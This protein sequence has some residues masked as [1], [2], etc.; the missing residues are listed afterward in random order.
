[1]NEFSKLDAVLEPSTPA[2]VDQ[3]LGAGGTPFNVMDS[4]VQSYEGL[5]AMANAVDRDM[6]R[7]YGGDST[8]DQAAI[9]GPL[10]R[11]IVE[12]FDVSKADED[13]N[14]TQKLPN[15]IEEMIPHK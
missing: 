4:L 11:M 3:Y 2:F 9:I 10:S 1:M 7:A 12:R 6:A 13:F 14:K 15:Y 8:S 5:A